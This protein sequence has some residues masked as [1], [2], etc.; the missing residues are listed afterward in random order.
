LR[1]R[2][3]RA[4]TA[5]GLESPFRGSSGTAT[6]ADRP[7]S[8]GSRG[9]RR[10]DSPLLEEH[11]CAASAIAHQRRARPSTRAARSRRS[12]STSRASIGDPVR[13][14][15]RL[16]S[17]RIRFL[18]SKHFAPNWGKVP[19]GVDQD[20]SQRPSICYS[21]T[22]ALRLAPRLLVVRA[23]GYESRTSEGPIA[24]GEAKSPPRSLDT[25]L[26]RGGGRVGSTAGTGIFIDGGTPRLPARPRSASNI[27]CNCS[28]L[29]T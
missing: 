16:T 24:C 2:G 3:N 21:S 7:S 22:E 11:V 15:V 6:T 29:S 13:S 28:T 8:T 10:R 4:A 26:D 19:R 5:C 14:C 1:S 18:P 9:S 20:R 12:R 27:R 17:L 25:W 23:I